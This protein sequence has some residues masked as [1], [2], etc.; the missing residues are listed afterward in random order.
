MLM[1][2]HVFF[3]LLYIGVV[4]CCYRGDQTFLIFMLMEFFCRC[5]LLLL[6]WRPTFHHHIHVH[7][8]SWLFFF[9]LLCVICCCYRGRPK[10]YHIRV[11]R[12]SWIFLYVLFIVVTVR[13]KFLYIRV[14]S[15]M[16]L[17]T[18]RKF[19]IFSCPVFLKIFR[20]L[21][22]QNFQICAKSRKFVWTYLEYHN[23]NI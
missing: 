1:G 10:C 6:P 9:V 20:F 22:F 21:I 11:N 18:W 8:I 4:C 19:N 13:P 5:Y 15:Q 17:Y 23:T 12:N 16:W 3:F 7:G 14:K 2:V